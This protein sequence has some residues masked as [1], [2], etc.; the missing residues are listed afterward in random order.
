MVLFSQRRGREVSSRQ[1][2][3]SSGVAV[4]E[5][6]NETTRVVIEPSRDFTVRHPKQ[7]IENLYN[8]NRGELGRNETNEI[9]KNLLHGLIL[10]LS[11]YVTLLFFWGFTS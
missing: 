2:K 10:T 11:I 9:I 3:Y 1:S 4:Q 6:L 8:Y 5:R 7:Q